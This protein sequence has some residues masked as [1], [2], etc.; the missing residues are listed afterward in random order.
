ITGCNPRNGLVAVQSVIIRVI[1]NLRSAPAAPVNSPDRQAGELLHNR[2]VARLTLNETA[3]VMHTSVSSTS[4]FQRVAIHTLAR[5]L[6]DSCQNDA[7]DGVHAGLDKLALATQA[8]DWQ[9]QMER[10]LASLR[11]SSPGVVSEVGKTITG[12]LGLLESVVSPCGGQV[13][14]KYVQPNLITALHPAVLR[15]VLIVAV[16]RATRFSSNG[17]IEI[18]ANL[19]G[20]NVKIS[21]STSIAEN[22]GLSANDIVGNIP[23]FEGVQV[24]VRIDA[25]N[26]FLWIEAPSVGRVRVL[27][28]DDNPDMVRFYRSATLGTR[29]EIIDLVQ[30]LDVFEMVET[31]RPDVIVLDVMLPDIDGWQILMRLHQNPATRSIPVIICTVMREESLGLSLG[32]TAYLTKPVGRSEFIQALD[33]VQ[34]QD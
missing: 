18:Y 3:E 29:Y 8:S 22:A 12:V 17:Q 30:V 32:A 5:V 28:V 26:L 23:A 20:G 4:R 9:S 6:W 10:E 16:E 21:V 1:E 15:Q 19:E 7:Q 33:E 2:F 25:A 14:V 31:S 24:Q 11:A 27:V 34:H 13:E